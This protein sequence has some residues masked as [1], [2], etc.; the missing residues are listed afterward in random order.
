MPGPIINGDKMVVSRPKKKRRCGSGH[1]G[2]VRKG[3]LFFIL[4]FKCLIN[5]ILFIHPVISTYTHIAL[6]KSTFSLWLLYR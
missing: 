4:F 1:G 3:A 6:F 2:A 5:V